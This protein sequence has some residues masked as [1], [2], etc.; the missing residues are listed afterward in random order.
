MADNLLHTISSRAV[1][2]AAFK[3]YHYKPTI[4]GAAIFIV[5]FAVSSAWHMWQA[6][7]TRSWFMIPLILGGLCE[8]M[9]K[10]A[11]S[12]ILTDHVNCCSQ[13]K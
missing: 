10:F 13:S 8:S 2:G 11:R 4:A 7:R 9:M 12:I 1:D 5:L 6:G 3:F